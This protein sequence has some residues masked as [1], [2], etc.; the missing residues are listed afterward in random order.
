LLTVFVDT[1]A[2]LSEVVN[3]GVADVR[4]DAGHLAVMGKGGRMRNLPLGTSALL[5]LDRY[6]RVRAAHPARHLPWYWLGERG[7]LTTSGVSQLLRRRGAEIG[8]PKLHPH[9]LRHTFAHQWLAAGGTEGDLMRLAGWRDAS[10][11]RRYGASAADE[12]A[13]A[14]HARLSPADRLR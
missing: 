14:A 3:L 9:Q 6:E 2:R 7:R 8:L 4:L 1:G 12:R 11:L 10:M 5:A 13:R